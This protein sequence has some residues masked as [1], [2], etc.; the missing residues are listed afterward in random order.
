VKAESISD[1]KRLVRGEQWRWARHLLRARDKAHNRAW[2]IL[3][4]AGPSPHEEIE[5]IRELM[6]NAHIVAVD[7]VEENLKAALE[8]GANEAFLCDIADFEV[9]TEQYKPTQYLL[10]MVLRGE[11]FDVICLDLTGPADDWLRRV[12][13]TYWH[14]ALALGGAMIINFSYG[15]DVTEVYL[16][17]WE[18]ARTISVG[19]FRNA[20][21]DRI[22]PRDM[23][24][25]IKA[26]VHYLLHSHITRMH[27]CLQYVGK[28]MPMVSC[29]VHK[30]TALAHTRFLKIL[31]DDFALAVTSTEDVSKIYACPADR[32]LELRR[33]FAAQKAVTVRQTRQRARYEQIEEAAN[34]AIALLEDKSARDED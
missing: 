4:I 15:R 9:I 5:S 31:P 14:A 30:K 34:E 21:P 10:P 28:R 3:I 17:S 19:H 29:L 7:L 13:M 6:R 18:H 1:Q 16:A 22:L 11:Q 23:P 12:F 20:H 32:I 2:R 33:S 25:E 24:Q 26:R 8:A 27:S